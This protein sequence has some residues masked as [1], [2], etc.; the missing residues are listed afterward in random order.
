MLEM[1][2]LEAIGFFLITFLLFLPI[3]VHP[4]VSYIATVTINPLQP[5]VTTSDPD[6]AEM[7]KDITAESSA[8][9][10]AADS[11]NILN[12]MTDNDLGG[13]KEIFNYAENNKD[14][15]HW[16][17]LNSESSG[18][19]K[20]EIRVYFSTLEVTPYDWRVYVYQSDANNINTG[21]YVDGSSSVTGWTAIDV[22]SIIHQ[23]DGQGFMKVRLISRIGN[24]NEGKKALISE[25][26]WRL[27]S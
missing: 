14:Y 11:E 1:K 2:G 23:L 15:A 8:D 13:A 27:T 20:V 9:S 7:L 19:S 4:N 5:V 16:Y 26:E 18:Y 21:Y 24:G 6:S 3:A 22:S 17:R 12:L 25:M 10:S